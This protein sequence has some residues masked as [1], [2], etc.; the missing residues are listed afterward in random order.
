MTDAITALIEQCRQAKKTYDD[1][2]KKMWATGQYNGRYAKKAG[3]LYKELR[4]TEELLLKEI[5][6]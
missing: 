3:L 2:Y 5:Y 6:K 4:H 1:Q